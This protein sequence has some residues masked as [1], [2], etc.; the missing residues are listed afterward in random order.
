MLKSDSLYNYGMQPVMYSEKQ[1][2]A[3]HVGWYRAGEDL[4][5]YRNGLRT[6]SVR[7]RCCFDPRWSLA[8]LITIFI[9]VIAIS[10]KQRILLFHVEL[11]CS[12]RPRHCLL[13]PLLSLHI[14]C[15]LLRIFV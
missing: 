8:L 12:P 13:C 15:Q 11:D 9:L 4:C 10:G 5:Y 7:Q 14:H 6:G 1:T 2:A 3:E